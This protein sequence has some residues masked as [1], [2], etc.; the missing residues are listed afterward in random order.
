[1]DT[2]NHFFRPP[3]FDRVSGM[4]LRVNASVMKPTLQ[5]VMYILI[6]FLSVRR[7]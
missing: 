3:C 7:S 2:L 5:V 4:F 1:M 6:V